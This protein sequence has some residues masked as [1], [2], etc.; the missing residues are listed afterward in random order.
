MTQVLILLTALHAYHGTK[1]Q[2]RDVAD[3]LADLA[4]YNA[5]YN[6]DQKDPR[7]NYDIDDDLKAIKKFN[8][9]CQKK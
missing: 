6:Q 5:V 2:C 7:K 4:T 1:A 8:K 9:E 3:A